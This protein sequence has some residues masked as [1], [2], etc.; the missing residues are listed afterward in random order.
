MN[1]EQMRSNYIENLI[2]YIK[3]EYFDDLPEILSQEMV[4]YLNS[5]FE[6]ATCLPNAAGGFCD[7]YKTRKENE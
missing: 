6:K 7:L 2:Q 4:E 1:T 5:C 3:M